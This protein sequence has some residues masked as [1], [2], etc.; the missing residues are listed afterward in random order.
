MY[1]LMCTLNFVADKLNADSDHVDYQVQRKMRI[2]VYR[3]YRR[4]GTDH[5]FKFKVPTMNPLCIWKHGSSVHWTSQDVRPLA[6]LLCPREFN[7][8]KGH[9][10]RYGET[11]NIHIGHCAS[12][13]SLRRL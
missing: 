11:D 6:L 9:Y 1:P 12:R 3:H 10:D 2:L 8:G 4:S 7:N 13:W 5:I